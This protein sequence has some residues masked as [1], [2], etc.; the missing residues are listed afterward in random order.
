MV[1]KASTMLVSKNPKAAILD[2]NQID[3]ILG[4]EVKEDEESPSNGKTPSSDDDS[5][6][7][8]MSSQDSIDFDKK[9]RLMLKKEK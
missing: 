9:I 4:E 1:A 6:V 3:E 7:T 8:S 2:L 5:S